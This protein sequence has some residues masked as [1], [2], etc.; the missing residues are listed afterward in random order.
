MRSISLSCGRRKAVQEMNPASHLFGGS[1]QTFHIAL[2]P[3]LDD[4]QLLWIIAA[5]HHNIL[6]PGCQQFPLTGLIPNA[7]HQALA[8]AFPVCGLERFCIAKDTMPF[9]NGSDLIG[10]DPHFD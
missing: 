7:G 10:A 3:P 1:I 5:L 8:Q 6:A 9:Q 4:F 2:E